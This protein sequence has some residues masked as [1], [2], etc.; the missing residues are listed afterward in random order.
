MRIALAIGAALFLIVP[1]SSILAHGAGYSLEQEA[2]EYRIDIGYDA[3]PRVDVSVRYDFEL[4]NAEGNP[5]DFDH[6]WVRILKGKSLLFAGPIGM[7]EGRI[8][9]LYTFPAEGMYTLETSFRTRGEELAQGQFEIAVAPSSQKRNWFSNPALI[10]AFLA[11]AVC[12]IMIG[13][14]SRAQEPT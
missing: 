6:I 11:A 7:R 12:G 5:S 8:T 14:F 3:E 10:L 4:L 9:L 2:G 1:L 13:R